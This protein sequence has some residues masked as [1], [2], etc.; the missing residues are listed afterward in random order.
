MGSVLRY[1]VLR[2][3]V[4]LG[5]LCVLWLVGLRGED[6]RLL[7]LALSLLL[8]MVVSYFLLRPFREDMSATIAA[9]VDSRVDRAEERR[10]DEASEE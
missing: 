6:Q 10:R 3:L 2:L 7:L 9:K 5:V 4:F 1:S 8:S